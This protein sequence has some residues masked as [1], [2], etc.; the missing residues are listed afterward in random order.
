MLAIRRQSRCA[1]RWGDGPVRPI[2]YTPPEPR[3]RSRLPPVC[4]RRTGQDGAADGVPRL[5][6]TL[7][8]H[9]ACLR[10][11]Q[12]TSAVDRVRRRRTA[13]PSRLTF[14]GDA[15]VA[16]SQLLVARHVVGPGPA[17]VPLQKVIAL[18][19]LAREDA[20]QVPR[21]KLRERR[22]RVVGESSEVAVSYTHLTLPT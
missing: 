10:R 3:V 16:A 20:P 7:P 18:G 8:G 15:V 21:R 13:R 22:D 9:A 12:H 1:V 11:A 14:V 5:G 2:A 6:S 19:R 17:E 4:R